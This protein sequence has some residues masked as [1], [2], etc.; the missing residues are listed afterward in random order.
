M[1]SHEQLVTST[2]RE[3][4]PTALLLNQGKAEY[5]LFYACVKSACSVFVCVFFFFLGSNTYLSFLCPVHTGENDPFSF[6]AFQE[7]LCTDRLVAKTNRAVE[8]L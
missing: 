3:S 8:T 2:S 4:V 7:Y 5:P 1:A 6:D